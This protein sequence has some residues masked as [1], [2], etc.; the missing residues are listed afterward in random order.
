M[1]H[2]PL[3]RVGAEP[4]PEASTGRRIRPEGDFERPS[5]LLALSV[6]VVDDDEDARQLV[7]A[8]LEECG[9]KVTAVDNVDSA[10]EVLSRGA[11]DVLVSDI[12]MPGQ[13]GYDLIRR[14]RAL[15]GD[16]ASLPAAALT[17]YAR[18]EDR[19]RALNAGYSKHLAKPVEP[20][21]LV[22]VVAELARA[23]APRSEAI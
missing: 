2:L 4:R 8:V 5:A 15:P 20:S 22:A 21:E 16:A 9:S 1:V 13:D 7:Q 6:L 17:A 12:G 11:T 23:R 10:L 3:S 18:A 14:V 19:H